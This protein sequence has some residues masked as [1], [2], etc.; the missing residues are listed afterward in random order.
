MKPMHLR[1]TDIRIQAERAWLDALLTFAPDV[2]GLIICAAPYIGHLRGSRDNYASGILHEAG[3]GTLLVSMLTPYEESRDPDVRYDVSLLGNRLNALLTWIDQQ[4]G[5]SDMPLGLQA[6]GTVVAASI[7]HLV[8]EPHRVSAL[9]SRAGRA[10]LA[11]ADPLR[12]LSVPILLQVP[13]EARD[14]LKPSQQAYAHLSGNKQWHEISNA[15]AG[16]IEPG[17]LESITREASDWFLQ[18]LPARPLP[19]AAEDTPTA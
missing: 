19:P 17:A 10:D 4:A 2:R 1:H 7:R 6:T 12:R 3:Y 11:G 5:L 15:S 18:H 8:R 9:V 16:F 14:L 13:G